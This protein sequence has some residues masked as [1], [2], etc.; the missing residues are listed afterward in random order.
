MH[1]MS[2][3]YNKQGLASAMDEDPRASRFAEFKFRELLAW[4]GKLPNH[5]LRGD[6]SAPYAQVLQ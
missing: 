1:D 3:A 2:L 4:S 5:L 6:C